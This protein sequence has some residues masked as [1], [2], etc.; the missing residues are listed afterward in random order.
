MEKLRDACDDFSN[1]ERYTTVIWTCLL[2]SIS[3]FKK[4]FEIL[5]QEFLLL[6][7]KKE[8]LSRLFFHR[9]Q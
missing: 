8:R 1:V 6:Q 9:K 4:A 3:A 5:K 2:H 7:Q